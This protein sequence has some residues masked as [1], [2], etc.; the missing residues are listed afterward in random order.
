[1]KYAVIVFVAALAVLGS[2]A[3]FTFNSRE[4][5]SWLAVEEARGTI[6]IISVSV[7]KSGDWGSLENEIAGLLPLFFSEES[8]RVVS[9]P[10]RADYCAEVK[11]RERE[12]PDG[13]RT[14][15]SL[16]AEVRFWSDEETSGLP[17]SAGRV[18]LQGNRSLASSKTLSG[19]L[20]KA[21][22]NAV[23]GLPAGVN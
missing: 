22:K 10:A 17:L 18:L 16:S 1:M 8:Y 5:D 12:Y 21:V 13:W 11:V 15:R 2:C 6:R 20:R 9:S 14:R 19:M 7:D 3:S 23:R 4:S